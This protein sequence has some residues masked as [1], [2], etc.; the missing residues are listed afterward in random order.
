MI[1]LVP[2]VIIAEGSVT[3]ELAVRAVAPLW[4]SLHTTVA[5]VEEL[6][7]TLLTRS[8]MLVSVSG[9]ISSPTADHSP[10][11]SL[12]VTE[13]SRETTS[14]SEAATFSARRKVLSASMRSTAASNTNTMVGNRMANSSAAR[15]L[16]AAPKRRRKLG[17]RLID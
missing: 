11:I 4:A 5:L 16:R 2:A 8:F 12:L 6:T 13:V 3:V 10:L 15:P 1:T 7:I 14:A 9:Y 17:A